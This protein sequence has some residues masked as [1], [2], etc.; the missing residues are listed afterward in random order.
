MTPHHRRHSNEELCTID[1]KVKLFSTY[2]T[3]LYTAQLW[4][5]YTKSAYQ[6]LKVAYNDALRMLLN[7]PR[8]ASASEMFAW[9]NL[10]GIDALIR[11]LIFSFM[12]RLEKS[13]NTVV[14]GLIDIFIS[15]VKFCSRIWKH[16][17][18][19]LY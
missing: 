19:C 3:P 2:C 18:S 17:Y 15:D 6:K 9:C 10:P 1:V 7:I 13:D 8:R 11:K 4:W 12:N 16:W 5:N 14:K